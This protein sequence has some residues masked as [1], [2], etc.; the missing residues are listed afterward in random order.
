MGAEE[1][2]GLGWLG[3]ASGLSFVIW[4]MG[5]VRWWLKQLLQE[6]GEGQMGPGSERGTVV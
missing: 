6:G 1:G 4:K 3:L 2:P 5:E